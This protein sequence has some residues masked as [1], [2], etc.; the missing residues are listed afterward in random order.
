MYKDHQGV[1]YGGVMSTYEA[2]LTTAGWPSITDIEDARDWLDGHAHHVH[3][4]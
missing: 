4:H 1:V 3:P 2:A